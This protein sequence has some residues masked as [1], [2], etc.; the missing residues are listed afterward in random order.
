[1]LVAVSVLSVVITEMQGN[2]L[3]QHRRSWTAQI[4]WILSS[5]ILA[6]A[7]L[8]HLKGSVAC[9]YSISYACSGIGIVGSY[10]RNPELATQVN[11]EGWTVQLWWILSGSIL[12][13]A[14][15]LLHLKGSVVCRYSNRYGAR[16]VISVVILQIRATVLKSTGRVLDSSTVDPF[17]IILAAAAEVLHLKGSVACAVTE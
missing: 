11:T 2:G 17:E 10:H 9:R 14:G 8:L 5:S 16:L 1:M 15:S 13:A 3:S 12:A 6:G 7:S 4:W